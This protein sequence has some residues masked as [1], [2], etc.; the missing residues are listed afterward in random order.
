MTNETSWAGMLDKLM[1]GGAPGAGGAAYPGSDPSA[2]GG[3]VGA[4]H[5][6]AEAIDRLCAVLPPKRAES[7]EGL[8]TSESRTDRSN[9]SWDLTTTRSSS[10]K[11]RATRRISLRKVFSPIFSTVTCRAAR[12]LRHF[13]WTRRNSRRRLRGRIL[14]WSPLISRRAIMPTLP[15]TG[16]RSKPTSSKMEKIC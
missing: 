12:S 14:R 13:Q 5:S 6:L 9:A 3:S 1:R 2:A 16:I 15:A 11:A 7:R 10:W 4:S 8:N